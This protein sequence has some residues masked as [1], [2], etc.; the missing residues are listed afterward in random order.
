MYYLSG[1]PGFSSNLRVLSPSVTAFK[2]ITGWE[3]LF[4]SEKNVPWIEFG[5][6]ICRLHA[7]EKAA[8]HCKGVGKTEGGV[9]LM[10]VWT[11]LGFKKR[12]ALTA[13]FPCD[14]VFLHLRCCSH[15][16]NSIGCHHSGIFEC[17]IQLLNRF[18]LFLLHAVEPSSV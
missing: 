4:Y 12:L 7:G 11:W 14:F 6:V 2:Q 10:L 9:Q 1:R 16:L 5:F 15:I 18:S 3:E 13:S 17:R 8:G